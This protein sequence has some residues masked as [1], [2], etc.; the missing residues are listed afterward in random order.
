ML[1]ASLVGTPATVD[2]LAGNIFGAKQEPTS[3]EVV[4]ISD[5]I[6]FR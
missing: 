4:G 1:N 6:K 3:K 5:E 2:S